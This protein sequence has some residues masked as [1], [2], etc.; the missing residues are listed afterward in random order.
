MKHTHESYKLSQIITIIIL[1]IVS[2]SVFLFFVFSEKL[3]EFSYLESNLKQEE[4]DYYANTIT[5]PEERINYDSDSQFANFRPLT[6]GK[7]K[8]DYLFRGASPYLD[9]ER[10]YYVN[11]FLEKYQINNI[12]SLSE[13]ETE[14]VDLL[15][16]NN[17]G[18]YFKNLH[19]NDLMNLIATDF[20]SID[21][22]NP[23]HVKKIDSIFKFIANN[24]EPKYIH[25]HIGR[26][27][28]GFICLVI[29][30]LAG[31]SYDE[32]LF[33]Y[34]ESFYNLSFIDKNNKSYK[35]VLENFNYTIHLITD[36]N[37]N[38][39]IRYEEIQPKT[40]KFLIKLGISEKTI[41]KLIQNISY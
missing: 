8:Q 37:I 32:M 16:K 27:R 2:S 5:Y 25:C 4:K 24:N 41:N 6:G 9:N 39:D 13:N 19:K 31:A 10:T 18:I 38:E 35:T 29:E 1:I 30:A 12:I 21:I 34:S 20:E 11:I 22:R 14:I 26:D 15:N 40:I 23:K 36:T 7:L 17:Y 3:E 28:T 33:D